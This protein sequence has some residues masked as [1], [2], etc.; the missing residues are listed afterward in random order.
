MTG[1]YLIPKIDPKVF[2]C[3]RRTVMEDKVENISKETSILPII[4]GAKAYPD[5]PQGIEIYYQNIPFPRKG[6]PDA[7]ILNALNIVKKD[8]IS[9]LMGFANKYLIPCYI[10]F[11]FFPYKWKL[12]VF[13]QFIHGYIRKANYWLDFWF[14]QPQYYCPFAAELKNLIKFFL[15]DL[16]INREYAHQLAMIG[17]MFMEHDDRFR[18][19]FQD[20]FSSTTKQRLLENPRKE[21]KIIAQLIQQREGFAFTK[22]RLNTVFVLLNWAL[23][24]PKI[25]RAFKK[26]IG[27]ID[28]PKLQ[29]TEADVYNALRWSNYN[30]LDI[31]FSERERIL[32]DYHR[33]LAPPPLLK[34]I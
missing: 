9:W 2:L 19:P 34:R 23:L 32:T 4:I 5:I 7:D 24:I 27:L 28:F 30:A 14:Y 17:I 18:L 21:L 3:A 13:N 6:F 22:E 10:V 20:A 33:N 1:Q 26:A 31:P 11:A 12:K 29:F 15:W 8:T 16:G 25:R